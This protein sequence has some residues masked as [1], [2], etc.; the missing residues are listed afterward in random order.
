ML[1]QERKQSGDEGYEEA[2]QDPTFAHLQGPDV[3]DNTFL[4]L[5]LDV[6]QQVYD[7]KRYV[8]KQGKYNGNCYSMDPRR[9]HKAPMTLVLTTILPEKIRPCGLAWTI[10]TYKRRRWTVNTH[11]RSLK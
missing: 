1:D 3:K 7:H 9:S 11:F 5:I 8:H 10:S 4:A 2:L 6:P